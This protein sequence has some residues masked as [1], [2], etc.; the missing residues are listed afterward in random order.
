MRQ[1]AT[2]TLGSS[3]FGVEVLLVRE[4]NRLLEITPVPHS[5]PYVRGLINL[6]GHVAT[7]LDLAARLKL[8]TRAGAAVHQVI[9][10]TNDELA[11]IRNA[12][13]R[14]DL[15]TCADSVGFVVDSIGDVVEVDDAQIQPVPAGHDGPGAEFLQG[16]AMLDRRL[17]SVLHVEHLLRFDNPSARGKA[18]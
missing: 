7:M 15:L 16:V 11:P 10:K 2:F 4:I 18:A 3:L 13:G 6:R 12:W 1:F 8:R 9:L 5:P 17:L 14:P